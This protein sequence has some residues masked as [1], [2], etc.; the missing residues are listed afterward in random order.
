MARM[1]G[2]GAHRRRLTPPGAALTMPVWRPPELHQVRHRVL[3]LV[4]LVAGLALLGTASAIVTAGVDR[5]TG[6]TMTE[7]HAVDQL[8]QHLDRTRSGVGL[9]MKLDALA[10]QKTTC[11]DTAGRTRRERVEYRYY[12]RDVGIPNADVFGAFRRYW[13]A[14]GYVVTKDDVPNSGRLTVSSP[15]DG[16][17]LSLIQDVRHDLI[18]AI[19]SPCTVEEKG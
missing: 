13:P 5:A 7:Q 14:H 10:K 12:I 9:P 1:T 2:L 17:T 4:G 8:Q 6:K 15:S 3:R 19:T 18:L 11:G 16:Y